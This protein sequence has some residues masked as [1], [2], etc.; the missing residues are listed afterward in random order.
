MTNTLA[1]YNARRQ[2][3]QLMNRAHHYTAMIATTG[4]PV[5]CYR[6]ALLIVAREQ[7]RQA[8]GLDTVQS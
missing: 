6:H 2:A 8:L 7:Y 4:Q 1:Q 3:H 5:G